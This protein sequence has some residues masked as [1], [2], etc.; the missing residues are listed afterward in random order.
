MENSST[1]SI[2]VKQSS[3]SC[4]FYSNYRE[5]LTGCDWLKRGERSFMF[6][7]RSAGRRSW[8]RSTECVS[9]SLAFVVPLCDLS[10]KAFF[11]SEGLVLYVLLLLCL[12]L[13]ETVPCRRICVLVLLC[14]NILMEFVID[15]ICL[16]HQ[17]LPGMLRRHLVQGRDELDYVLDVVSDV[18]KRCVVWLLL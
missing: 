1:A 6:R 10:S 15:I 4:F 12:V 9:L 5:D 18:E 11:T 17:Y 16:K 2:I 7:F 14:Q 8:L 13:F 3:L